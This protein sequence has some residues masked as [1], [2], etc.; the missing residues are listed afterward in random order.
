M[1][2]SKHSAVQTRLGAALGDG[3]LRPKGCKSCCCELRQDS[4][5]RPGYCNVGSQGIAVP[6]PLIRRAGF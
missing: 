1:G 4:N 2:T 5:Q 6:Q 3:S